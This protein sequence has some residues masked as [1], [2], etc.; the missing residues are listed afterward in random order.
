MTKQRFAVAVIS[1]GC[2]TS[3]DWL[4]GPPYGGRWWRSTAGYPSVATSAQ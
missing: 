2:D 1:Y 4:Q 3:Y